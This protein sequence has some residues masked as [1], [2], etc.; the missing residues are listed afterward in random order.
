MQVKNIPPMTVLFDSKKTTIAGLSDHVRIIARKLYQEAIQRGAEITGPI[1]WCYYGMDGNPTTEFTL[2]I[3]LPVSAETP[4]TGEFK[5]KTLSK[6][7]CASV[8]HTGAW[9]RLSETYG[10]LIS[11]VQAQK[12]HMNGLFREAYINIDFDHPENNF[13]EVQVGLN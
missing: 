9:D 4:N 3:A 1:Y 5:F 10:S 6:F 12:L 8:L 7:R 2:E 11:G 13:T